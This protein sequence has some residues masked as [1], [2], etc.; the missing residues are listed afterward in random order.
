M[1]ALFIILICSFPLQRPNWEVRNSAAD[2]II[3]EVG[4]CLQSTRVS[5]T[6]KS[7]LIPAVNSVFASRLFV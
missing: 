5:I 2:S 3:S 4:F 1:N 6:S 7:P